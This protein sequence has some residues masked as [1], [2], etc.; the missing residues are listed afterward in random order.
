M[1][2]KSYQDGAGDPTKK[3]NMKMI[4]FP[5]LL[6]LVE[7]DDVTVYWEN[8]ER[9]PDWEV[10]HMKRDNYTKDLHNIKCRIISNYGNLPEIDEIY[11]D[12]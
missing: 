11:K 10:I 1:S 4:L 7:C 6:K 12:L 2:L 9:F 5:E 3:L 8:E